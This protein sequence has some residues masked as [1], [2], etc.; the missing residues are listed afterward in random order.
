MVLYGSDIQAA[1]EECL[2][3]QELYGL[4]YVPAGDDALVIA[5]HG[6]IG[7]EILKQADM[8]R[9][10]A[11]VCPVAC[12]ALIAG[13]GMYVKRV[14]PHVKVIGVERIEADTLSQSLCHRG[15]PL[16][17]EQIRPSKLNEEIIN[18]CAQVVDDIV[19]VDDQAISGATREA[20]EDT[21]HILQ[22]E[23]AMTIAGLKEWVTSNGW[24]GSAIDVVAVASEANVDF[25]TIPRIIEQA[26]V[27]EK[28]IVPSASNF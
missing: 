9:L 2:R 8:S 17:N 26:A 5:G 7:P 21:Q 20:F 10:E 22:P 16:L 25:F 23:G 14:A 18:I 12:G 24:V 13:L 3:L 1:K 4:V 11:I 6:T 15:K 28:A 19:L 27:P